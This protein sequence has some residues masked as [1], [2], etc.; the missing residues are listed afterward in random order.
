MDINSSSLKK[1]RRLLN[2]PTRRRIDKRST[3]GIAKSL[4]V[5]AI[6]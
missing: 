5:I 6:P 3:I 2:D 4:M 1:T